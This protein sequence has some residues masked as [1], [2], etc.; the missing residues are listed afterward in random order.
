MAIRV[1][2]DAG[3]TLP[4]VLVAMSLLVVAVTALARL[5]AVAIRLHAGARDATEASALALQKMEQ[6]RSLAWGF[7]RAGLRVSDTT[8]DLTVTPERATGG[9]GL[10]PS[11]AG[12]LAANTA[13]YCEFLDAFGRSLGGGVTMPAGAVYV[14]RWAIAPLASNPSDTLV[15]HVV[16]TRADAPA[17]K[18][19]AAPGQAALVSVRTRKAG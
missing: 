16:V 1:S 14:R 19:D 12:S 15:L 6:L 13:G 10:Q 8:T 5:S 4:E 2:R 11:P 3:F 17:P 7:D 9:R 18:G